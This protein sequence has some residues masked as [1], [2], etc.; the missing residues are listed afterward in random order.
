MSR[1][2]SLE[3]LCYKNMLKEVVKV[4]DP[5]ILNDNLENLKKCSVVYIE[6]KE[7]LIPLTIIS[8]LRNLIIMELEVLL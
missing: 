1:T 7:H 8:Y 2:Y 6:L 4:E 5:G 3:K